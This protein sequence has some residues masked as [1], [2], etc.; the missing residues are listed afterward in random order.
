MKNTLSINIQTFEMV[1][2]LELGFA[3]GSIWGNLYE[4]YKMENSYANNSVSPI[5]QVK[6]LISVYSFALLELKLY[7]LT[8]PNCLDSRETYKKIKIEH[9]KLV[10]YLN[11]YEEEIK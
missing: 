8:H 5:E 9:D 3:R 10:A 11:A 7:M 6:Y 4:P 1:S 2:N